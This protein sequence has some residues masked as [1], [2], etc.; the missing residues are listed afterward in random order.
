MNIIK[1]GVLI[2]I[3]A[4]MLVTLGLFNAISG[5]FDWL[6]MLIVTSDKTCVKCGHHHENVDR[7]HP[8]CNECEI[9]CEDDI[10][11]PPHEITREDLAMYR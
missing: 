3:A 10:M 8:F 9:E 11:T 6:A 4:V 2:I 5:F 1:H 7:K